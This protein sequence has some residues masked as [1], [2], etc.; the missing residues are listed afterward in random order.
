M[1]SITIA[2]LLLATAFYSAYSQHYYKGWHMGNV[3]SNQVYGANIDKT[4]R[5]IIQKNLPKRKIIVAVIDSGIDTTHEDLKPIIWTN[6]KEIPSNGMDD[7]KNGYVDDVHGWNFIGGKDGRNVGKDSYEGARI[8]YKLKKIFGADSVDETKLDPVKLDQY[9]LYKKVYT[10]LDN[11]A[12]EASMYVM[13]LKDI[14]AKIPSA[15]SLLKT[16]LGKNDYTGDDLQ[17]FKSND[18]AVGKARGIMLGLFQQTRQM[19]NTNTNLISELIQFYEG[20]KSKVEALEKEPPHYRDDI[21]KDRYDDPQDKFYG[22]ND[23]MG[24]DATH[25]TH[26]SGI[27]AAVRNNQKGIDGIAN[28]VEIMPVRAVPD[29]D[30]HDKDI[31]NAI[32][33]AV[34]NGAWVINMSFGKSFS[35][36]KKWVDEAVRYA[37]SKGVLLVHAAGNDAK[38]IDIEDNFPSRN[39]NNDTLKIFSNWI[40]VGASGALPDEIAASFSNFGKR[41]VDVFAPG[42]KIYS[43]IPGGN[44]YGDKDGTSMASPVVSGIAALILSYY[45][46]LSPQQLIE[47]L[48]KSSQKI[49]I[50]VTK[51]GTEGQKTNLN[52]LSITGGII[53]AYEAMKM[54]SKTKGER[55][56]TST[57]PL[58][59]K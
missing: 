39:F 5:E 50:P 35:P 26:V 3:D 7:D 44:A 16:S 32:R 17:N 55:K 33:Y 42:V 29:G 11:Q 56:I 25:G 46:E 8:Y 28:N 58:K 31:A 19:D 14:V 9:K 4:Y 34:D 53:D 52:E 6:K 38:N 2:L 23:I 48:T 12:K 59:K 49:D 18:P 13:I 24:T 36:E 30:E 45:P 15:D 47:I 22:N 40:T 54:A 43:T 37:E 51:P 10:Q 27:I 21:V 41:E 20:E 57:P 1:K